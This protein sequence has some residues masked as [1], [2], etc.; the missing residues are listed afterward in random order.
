MRN[1]STAD[2]K[3]EYYLD[4][5]GT[6]PGGDGGGIYSSGSLTI[7]KSRIESN[8]AGDGGR[9]WQWEGDH[10]GSGGGVYVASG[11]ATMMQ[12]SV[13]HNQAGN[14]GSAGCSRPS[15]C[16][17]R[18]G[19]GGSG[20]GAYVAAGAATA[21]LESSIF[22][23]HTGSGGAGARVNGLDGEGGGIYVAGVLSATNTTV[24]GNDS[25]G[26]AG[27]SRLGFSTVADNARYG[28]SG[29]ANL[30]NTIVAGNAL[31]GDGQDCIGT[32]TS[33]GYN[34]LGNS[35]GCSIT[36]DTTGLLLDVD[37][38]LVPLADN[39]G[40]TQTHALLEGSPAIDA[41]TCLDFDGT[42][43]TVD[44]RGI[45]RPQG[46]HCDIGAV[47][48]ESYYQSNLYFSLALRN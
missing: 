3:I 32:L 27:A 36:G 16:I 39:G 9:T 7:T 2:G 17:A 10:G 19:D 30:R 31:E 18:A 8:R 38:L 5:S 25:G 37:P 28:I 43:V 44:Q 45:D 33:V 24:S 23:N 14:G 13:A 1:N 12:S 41:G 40:P 11:T 35:A 15:Y 26:V 48:Q 4:G 47:E 20:G 22:E 42:P 34:L 46:S 21:V 29:S 6:G